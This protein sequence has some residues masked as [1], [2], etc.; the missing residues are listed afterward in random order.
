MR[1]VSQ[2]YLPFRF[3]A[4]LNE[5]LPTRAAEFSISAETSGNMASE[6]TRTAIQ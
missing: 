6:L 1:L 4:L 2:F 5:K 3:G